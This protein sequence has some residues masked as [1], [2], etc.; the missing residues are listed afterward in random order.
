MDYEAKLTS[1]FCCFKCRG[2]TAVARTAML[3]RGLPHLLALA[4][5]K[6]LLVTCTLC[7]YTEMYD[8]QVYSRDEE[9]VSARSPAE[10]PQKS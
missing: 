7:G 2:R 1:D 4:P 10:L 9:E 6:Y 3:S 8:P 5:D